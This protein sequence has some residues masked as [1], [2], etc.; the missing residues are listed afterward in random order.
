M[1]NNF[2]LS[3][4]PHL[5]V[6]AQRDGGTPPEKSA[7]PPPFA[8]A[9]A[10]PE[11]EKLLSE[12]GFF[13]ISTAVVQ[14]DSRFSI[15]QG[16][17]TLCVPRP[18]PSP[19]EGGAFPVCYAA[20]R[21]DLSWENLRGA[22]VAAVRSSAPSSVSLASC[23]THFARIC[24]EPPP[25][26]GAPFAGA[27]ARGRSPLSLAVTTVSFR[28]KRWGYIDKTKLFSTLPPLTRSPSPNRGGFSAGSRPRPTVEDARRNTSSVA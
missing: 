3:M 18:T 17:T 11:G 5:F 7:S 23:E 19:L 16:G 2:V 21:C 22:A 25:D 10:P 20:R 13:I 28:R 24:R 1:E 4:Y 14:A 12:E 6:S 15:Y 9:N 8:P 26:G 27:N